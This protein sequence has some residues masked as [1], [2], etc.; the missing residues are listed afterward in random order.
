MSALANLA[1]YTGCYDQFL[2][3]RQRYSLKWSKGDSLQH[4]QLFF[5]EDLSFDTMLQR[6]KEMIAK[7]PFG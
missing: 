2:Q 7:T 6:I 4:F 5:S 3:L 1:K